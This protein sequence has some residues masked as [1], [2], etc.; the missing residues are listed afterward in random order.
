MTSLTDRSGDDHPVP[1]DEAPGGERI[2]PAGGSMV[3]DENLVVLDRD[4]AVPADDQAAPGDDPLVLDEDMVVLEGQ[5]VPAEDPVVPDQDSAVPDQDPVVSAEDPVVPDQDSAV[6][7]QDQTTLE[8]AAPDGADAV[9]GPQPGADRGSVPGS[10]GVREDGS[11]SARWPAIQSMFVDDPRAS[12]ELAAGLTDDSVQALM[13]TVKER[14]QA[15]LSAWQGNGTGTE[16][17]RTALQAYRA[18]WNR[19]DTFSRDA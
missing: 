7:D 3:P 5:I 19:V 15:L 8:S 17:L 16:E 10:N 18:F 9:A 6:P 11:A 14:Q 12:V 2:V 4:Q 13:A 1:G